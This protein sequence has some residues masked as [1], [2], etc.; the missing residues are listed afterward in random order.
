VD[1]GAAVPTLSAWGTPP[2]AAFLILTMGWAARRRR[3]AA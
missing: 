1:Q 3:L 2:L